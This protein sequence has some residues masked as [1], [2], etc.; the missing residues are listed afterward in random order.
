KIP[1]LSDLPLVKFLEASGSVRLSEYNTIGSTT[2]WTVGGRYEPIDWITFRGTYSK[3]V[4][5]PNIGELFS[6]LQPASIGATQDPCN[7][8]FINAGTQFRQANCLMFVAPGFNSTTFNSAFVPG[9][10]GGNPNLSE[11]QATTI[12]AGFVFNPKGVLE[13]L[14]VISDFYDIKLN[15]AIDALGA[16]DIAQACVDLPSINN[17]FCNQIFRD[18]IDGFITGF[19]SGQINLGALETRGVDWSVT[20]DFEVPSIGGR[21]NL[22]NLTLSSVGTRFLRFNEFQDP[23][24]L[25]VFE[26]RLGA[27]A[28]PRWIVNFGADWTLSDL[29]LGWSGR[30]ESSQLLPGIDNS[31]IASAVTPDYR[32]V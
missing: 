1:V 17:Q 21:Q 9:L 15:G 31:D 23:T 12:T 26:D 32:P 27:F 24:D 28:R 16:F 22:G 8:Q 30:F 7:P 20:Y 19:V 25:T 13:G 11:E 18:P 6:P 29:R 10:S 2:A 4:R 14:T 5:S 3:S